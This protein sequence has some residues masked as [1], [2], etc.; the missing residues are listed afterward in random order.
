VYFGISLLKISTL[1]S[2]YA[3]RFLV[4]NVRL[5]DILCDKIRLGSMRVAALL[6]TQAQLTGVDFA[7]VNL[8]GILMVDSCTTT[9][10]MSVRFSLPYTSPGYTSQPS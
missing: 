9:H 1:A 4:V 7:V 8:A 3:Q 2:R 6:V 10:R 5:A